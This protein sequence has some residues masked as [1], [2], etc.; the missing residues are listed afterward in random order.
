MRFGFC[1]ECEALGAVVDEAQD[2]AN[3][4]ATALLQVVDRLPVA[5]GPQALEELA[6]AREAW[7]HRVALAGRQARAWEAHERAHEAAVSAEEAEGAVLQ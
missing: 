4:E 3:R 6:R 2:A 1:A 5:P 7:R